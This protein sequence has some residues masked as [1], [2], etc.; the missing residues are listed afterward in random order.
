MG[1][2]ETVRGMIVPFKTHYI[3]L[4]P[5]ISEYIDAI[6]SAEDNFDELRDLRPVMDADGNPV[7][8]SGNFAVVF[9]MTD[10][11][12]CYAIKCFTKDQ[13]GRADA[14]KLIEQELA[15]INSPY[16]VNLR[17]LENELYVDTRQTSETQFPVLRMDWVEGKPL[18]VFIQENIND[19]HYGVVI[20]YN[21][22]KLAQWLMKQPFAHGDLKPDNILVRFD[23]TLALVDYDGMFVP[24]MAN[25]P[26]REMGTPEY[27]HP[28]RTINEFNAHIDDYALCLILLY[29]KTA[30]LEPA[31]QT[32]PSF[33]SLLDDLVFTPIQQRK[34]AM[35]ISRLM[36]DV[37]FMKLYALFLNVYC[38][39]DL[40]GCP[41]KLLKL[42]GFDK[43]YNVNELMSRA[44]QNDGL[45]C[46]ELGHYY[47]DLE[48]YPEAFKWYKLATE[49]NIQYAFCG[50]CRC[51][52]SNP[53][54]SKQEIFQEFRN[55]AK[56]GSPMAK[57][58]MGWYYSS[59][60]E[61]NSIVADDKKAFEYKLEAA[62]MGFP[63]AQ[64]SLG[65]GYEHG[66][67]VEKNEKLAVEWYR[68]AA[69]Q[70]YAPAQ[71]DLGVCYNF[72]KGVK[73][74]EAMTV[75]WIRKA[76]EQGYARAQR[77]LGVCYEYGKGVEK[78]ETLAVEWYRKA[79]EQGL[80]RA[81]RNLGV[82]YE[83][84]KG[85][86]KNE[87]LAVE[88]YRKAAE[89]GNA[90]AQCNL[91]FCYHKG[92][93]VEKNETLAV[94][95]YRKAAEQG[96]ARAQCI[97]GVCYEYGKGVEKNETLAVEWYRK[98][99]EQGLAR[100]QCSLG[101]CYEYGRGVEKNEK[102]AVE[103][104]RKAAE[105][106]DADAQCNLGVC[107]NYGTGVEK[108][109]T[110]AV[111]WYRKAAEQ[112]NAIAQCNLG[113]CYEGGIGV[114]KNET[115]AV[116]WYRKAAEQ[117]LARAQF[118]LGG[119]YEN[120]TGLDVDLFKA[121]ELYTQALENGEA[122]AQDAL[123]RVNQK[124]PAAPFPDFNAITPSDDLPF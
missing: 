17:Y 22:S 25:Q 10:G 34:N 30:F 81:Q 101:V 28:E 15:P 123:D 19:E 84:G 74:N 3:M 41:S 79:A 87:K 94:E 26:A 4:Y 104:Y 109:E 122:K 54:K 52:Y 33:F 107:Y 13:P 58:R 12:K 46:Y 60:N 88:W 85:V 35:E 55:A 64:C 7:M 63:Q 110:L 70:G 11:E 39:R 6:R 65:I 48:D 120:G 102:L 36:N 40:R 51:T 2:G 116:E 59:D 93:G 38:N 106:G 111:E 90:I 115:L 121:R 71:C 97:L 24:A 100:A 118:R 114:E 72:G 45:A 5:T 1:S 76:A 92:I 67:G 50:I 27:R 91:G 66:T 96:L 89:Q 47:E 124:I 119:C 32:M 99:A 56:Y 29:T 8:S 16:I 49:N 105:Q 75:E 37:E 108:N 77:N 62:K 98:A 23:G 43:R 86:E 21:F 14:Y 82:C 117:G 113:V 42:Q 31:F 103:W 112:G 44:F 9:K 20:P 69:E 73:R 61:D 68:K 95:W 57:C 78:N 18:D 53:D 80:A 83:Y